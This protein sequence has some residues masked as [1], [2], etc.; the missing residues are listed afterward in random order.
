[1][2]FPIATPFR[3]RVLRCA[4][5]RL[6]GSGWQPSLM[7]RCRRDALLLS[8]LGVLAAAPAFGG[9]ANRFA[10]VE[11][12]AIPVTEGISML[13]GAGGN[14]A[15]SIGPDGALMVDDQFAPLSERI[16]AAIHRL[17]GDLP[18][19]VINTHYHGDHV[20]GNPFFARAGT[21]LAQDN[22]R[23]RLLGGDAPADGLPTITF[24]DRLR[25]FFNGDEVMVLHLPRGHTDGDALVW[26]KKAGV[27]HLGDLLFNGR[28]PYVDLA[29]GGSVDGLLANLRKVLEQ[30]PEDIRIIPGHGPLAGISELEEAI[31]VIQ[32]TQAVV[33]QAVAEGALEELKQRG[34]GRW[35]DWGSGF[36]S[37]QRWI[38]IIVQ[39]DATKD[40]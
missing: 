31:D 40:D 37:E 15:V 33:R 9:P 26:F 4:I 5:Q 2:I 6:L 20:G 28:F 24:R 34:F 30:L 38:D 1:M 10:E 22:V 14:I 21:I 18:V 11:I 12:K 7:R 16:A 23:R 17:G 35:E 39:N 3:F 36:I 19:F 27:I 29:G 32:E 25:L 13:E 8:G